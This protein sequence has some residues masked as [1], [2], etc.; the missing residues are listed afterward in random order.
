MPQQGKI[1]LRLAKVPALTLQYISP[2]VVNVPKGQEDQ[3]TPGRGPPTSDG[4]KFMLLDKMFGLNFESVVPQLVAE[5]GVTLLELSTRFHC[6]MTCGLL[7]TGIAFKMGG[8]WSNSTT[9]VASTLILTNAGIH[10]DFEYVSCPL[11]VAPPIELI[12][13]IDADTWSN[14]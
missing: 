3:F 10:V 11:N 1:T 14:D 4:L 8:H 6:A 2:P 5:A 13:T 9:E 7:G 12:F